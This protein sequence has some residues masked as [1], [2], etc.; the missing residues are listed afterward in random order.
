MPEMDRS[1]QGLGRC[2]GAA[3]VRFSMRALRLLLMVGGASAAFV[4]GRGHAEAEGRTFVWNGN[5]N[6]TSFA[7]SGNWDR[8]WEEGGQPVLDG[9][10]NPMY[11]QIPVVGADG[12]PLFEKVPVTDEE[13]NT[14][15]DE[16]GNQIFEHETDEDGNPILGED[17]KPVL[18]VGDQIFEPGAPLLVEP[19]WV[20]G[21]P[22]GLDTMV[23]TAGTPNINS[24]G[25]HVLDVNLSG[26]EFISRNSKFN[27]S[28]FYIDGTLDISGSGAVQIGEGA[29][30]KSILTAAKVNLSSG[31]IGG[32]LDPDTD[33]SG[34]GLLV[35][36]ESMEQSGGK[37][38]D[39]EIQ[40]PS[41]ALSGGTLSAKVDFETEFTLSGE[42]TVEAAAVLRGGEGSAMTQS[43]GTMAGTVSGIASYTHS[44]GLISG[45]VSTANYALTDS[46]ATSAG[47][48]ITASE[49]F[50]LAPVSGTALVEARLSGAGNLIKSGDSTVVLANGQN[51]FSGTVAVNAGTLEVLDDALPD[52]SAVSVAD[53]ATLVMNT[54]ND[55]VFMG[56][57]DGATGE[58][59]KEGAATLTLGGDVTLGGLNLN[60]GR[61]EVGTGTSH[62]Y[63]VVRLRRRR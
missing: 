18:K 55:T 63:G 59:V 37:V 50:D 54:A 36:T 32:W 22:D 14:L 46:S 51:D 17:G 44:G 21:P 2:G 27:I 34:A 10:G 20:E 28:T 8:I 16:E 62:Q 4:A 38:S 60:A 23:V 48:L 43:G 25:R 45:E 1:A 31:S 61:V 29:F 49:S 33:T 35:V 26:G 40:T 30:G 13:G 56:T 19:H 39:I 53:G 6:Q 11:E 57:I 24:Q 47:G 12:K 41:Y 42:G 58:L 5:D 15:W 3:R 9:D 52:Y 7:K